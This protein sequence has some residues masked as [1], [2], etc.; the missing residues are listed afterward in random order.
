MPLQQARDVII[1]VKSQTTQGTEE[2]SGSG[3]TRFIYKDGSA[4]FSPPQAALIESTTN[5][6]DGMTARGRRGSYSVPGQ[7]TI[8]AA[9]GMHQLI[10]P[11]YFR[12]DWAAALT[13]T[14]A[15]VSSATLS[16]TNTSE[17]NLSAQSWMTAGLRAGDAIKFTAGLDAADNGK[18]LRIKTL[19]ALKI[20]VYETLTNVAGPVASWSVTRAPKLSQGILPKILTF[21]TYFANMDRSYVTH[22]VKGNTLGFALTE[23]STLDVSLDLLGAGYRYKN[24]SGPHFTG[25]TVSARTSLAFLDACFGV[26]GGELLAVT[27]FN[28]GLEL[29]ASTLAVAN[30][31]GPTPGKSPDVFQSNGKPNGQWTMTISDF[32]QLSAAAA[33]T[34]IDF[35]ARFRDPDTNDVFQLS[36]EN[37][38]T[39]GEQ[40]SNIG[41]DGALLQ[42]FDLDI[43][44]DPRGG[45]FEPSAIRLFDSAVV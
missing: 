12:N 14:E 31:C 32:A 26:A 33:E 38:I 40:F 45:A 43:G 39:Y 30:G 13:L 25:P 16:V 7:F 21:D 27:G 3:A 2:A 35:I 20:T 4:G 19:T 37:A 34:R 6:G 17:I 8:E 23:N 10:Y 28:L 29:S 36:V 41:T 15:S 22:D 9:C 11:T 18:W 42:T 24:T 44:R 1:A 5:F